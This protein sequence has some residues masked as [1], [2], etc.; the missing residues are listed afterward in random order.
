[1]TDEELLVRD[2]EL[3]GRPAAT[4]LEWAADRF[5]PGITFA[6]G[7]GVEGCVLIDLIARRNLPI[8]IFT[9]DTG[10]LFP[11]TYALWE[12][13]ERRYRITIRPVRPGL[14]VEAQAEQVGAQLWDSNPDR[15]CEIRKVLPL[16]WALTG[17][18]AWV[19]AIRRDQTPDRLGA[20]VLERD[21]RFGLVKVNPLA[22]WTSA[23]VW[24]Y[25]RKHHLPYNPLHDQGYPSIGCIPCT[26]PVLEGEDP[27]AGR[28]RGRAKK[29]CGLHARAARPITS[30]RGQP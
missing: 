7:F 20:R 2:R 5:S 16:R 19:S 23:D 24:S 29:E 26:S 12:Q 11:Q 1:M 22:S 27:R 28:W 30:A 17:F 3:E 9:L 14:S 4:I 15:C 6:T 18:K 8:D 10:L 25:V 21:Q 13:L